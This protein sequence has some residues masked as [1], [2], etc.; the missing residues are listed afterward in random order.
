M[1]E[2]HRVPTYTKR[3]IVK[4]VAVLS[5]ENINTT[6]RLV[7]HV[8]TALR[9]TITSADPELRIEVRDFGVFE[10][11]VTKS[12]PKARN[13]KSGEIIYVPPHRKTH[14]KPSKLLKKY[15][16]QPL[17]GEFVETISKLSQD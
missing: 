9:E 5:R 3:D 17:N 10:V 1:N 16:S 14:F 4:R 2:R 11:K 13:P 7:E 12:K 6:A 8:F 15:L